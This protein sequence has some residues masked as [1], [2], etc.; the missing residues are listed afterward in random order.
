MRTR[1]LITGLLAM[2]LT[3]FGQAAMAADYGFFYSTKI[4]STKVDGGGFSDSDLS[5]HPSFGYDFNDTWGVVLGYDSF[6]KQDDTCGTGCFIKLREA[7]G[8]NL[9]IIGTMPLNEKWSLYGS[10][11]WQHWKI[12]TKITDQGVVTLPPSEDGDD[13]IIGVGVKVMAIP[14]WNLRFRAGFDYFEADSVDISTFYVGAE[15]KFH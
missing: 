5:M 10:A 7:T 9:R 13:F 12:K 6:G 15:K 3:G 2:I 8:F 11:G 1:I 14:K 4:G